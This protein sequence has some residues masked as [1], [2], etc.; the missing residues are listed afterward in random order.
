M[1]RYPSA[2]VKGFCPRGA[3]QNTWPHRGNSISSQ[4]VGQ[5]ASS[6]SVALD[7]GMRVATNDRVS[8]K[9]CCSR[10]ERRATHRLRLIMKGL[11]FVGKAHGARPHR[12]SGMLIPEQEDIGFLDWEDNLLGLRS[13]F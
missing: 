12:V 10:T 3:R 6:R 1:D 11:Q 9:S 5:D 4:V 2:S 8:L 7:M 13:G